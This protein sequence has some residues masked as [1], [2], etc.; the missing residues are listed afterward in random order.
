[1]TARD[2]RAWTIIAL[3]FIPVLAIANHY[4]TTGTGT[5]F[6]LLVVATTITLTLILAWA[7]RRHLEETHPYR[8]RRTVR[9]LDE[10]S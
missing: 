9:T 2:A 3:T 1:M 8:A 4:A 7:R 5:G 6:G 10:I